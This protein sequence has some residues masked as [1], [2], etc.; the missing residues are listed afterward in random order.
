[1][2]EFQASNITHHKSNESESKETKINK[3][4]PLIF[5]ILFKPPSARRK[6]DKSTT[7][8]PKKAAAETRRRKK[9]LS[10]LSKNKHE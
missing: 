8:N 1:M 7:T 6:T 10:K 4:F 5:T 3:K 2:T 9:E